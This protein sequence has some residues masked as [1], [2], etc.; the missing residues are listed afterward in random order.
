MRAT[1]NKNLPSCELR[2]AFLIG[3]SLLLLACPTD[4]PTAL[5]QTPTTPDGT[6]SASWVVTITGSAGSLETNGTPSTLTISIRRA[7]TNELPPDGATAAIS[8]TLGRFDDPV[9]GPSSGVVS[10][11]GGLA[12]VRLFPGDEAG[13]AIVQ[14]QIES[15]VGSLSIDILQAVI[16]DFLVT[17]VTPSE[18]GTSGGDEIEVMGQ[19]FVEPLRVFFGD[20]PAEVLSVVND[21]ILALSPPGSA[22]FADVNVSIRYGS[23]DEET[24]EFISGFLY[25]D[26][27]PFISSIDPVEGSFVGGTELNIYGSGF[28]ANRNRV[29]VEIGGKRQVVRSSDSKQIVAITER[30]FPNSCTD[31]PGEVTVTIRDT[32]LTAGG[33]QF[34]F[35]VEEKA[36][37]LTSVSPTLLVCPG[38]CVGR[39]LTVRGNRLGAKRLGATIHTTSGFEASVPLTRAGN[40]LTLRLPPFGVG[41]FDTQQCPAGSARTEI[42]IDTSFSV[43]VEDEDTTCSD[44]LSLAVLVEPDPAETNCT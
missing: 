13:T 36:P 28:P 35:L 30:I 16:Q 23:P 20:A 42:P 37:I 18:G 32:G 24:F 19:G 17:G 41:F 9:T 40:T 27:G 22:G 14:V 15:S 6:P 26:E 21:L 39:D 2:W 29:F 44:T 12:Q 43:T 5:K 38:D 33:P 34:T 1:L 25:R 4:S 31:V 11:V 8:T 3:V 10:L 7:S